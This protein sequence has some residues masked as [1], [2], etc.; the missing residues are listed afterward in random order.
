MIE[1]FLSGSADVLQPLILFI[2]FITT[3]FGI[4]LGVLPGVSGGTAVVL[5]LPFLYGKDPLI[6]LPIMCTLFAVSNTGGSLTAILTGIPGD[7]SNAATVL[8]GSDLRQPLGRAELQRQAEPFQSGRPPGGLR[9]YVY[10]AIPLPPPET[11]DIPELLWQTYTQDADGPFDRLLLDDAAMLALRPTQ[12]WGASKVQTVGDDTVLTFGGRGS[13][14]RLD[15]IDSFRDADQIAFTLDYKRAAPDIFSSGLVRN[16]GQ[17]DL[18]QTGDGLILQ[19]ATAT[20]GLKRYDIRNLGLRD[21]DPHEVSVLFDPVN[22]QLKLYLDEVLVFRDDTTDLV[23]VNPQGAAREGWVLGRGF[24]GT[25]EEFDLSE[26]I[27]QP[28]LDG[29]VFLLLR[30]A[31]PASRQDRDPQGLRPDQKSFHFA[32]FPSKLAL[33]QIVIC[34]YVICASWHGPLG[35]AGAGR[36]WG[37]RS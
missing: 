24:T 3:V 20:E 25:I 19:V 13:E 18:S 15:V 2:I 33:N 31:R 26:N 32:D 28:F 5:L 21:T 9:H 10:G 1:A 14:V 17:L 27:N 22:D 16:G 7:N 29:D 12:L 35:A 11:T 34:A 6:F 30:G 36:S 8:E 4:I 37:S 23:M